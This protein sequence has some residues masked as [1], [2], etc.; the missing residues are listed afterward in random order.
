MT[1]LDLDAIQQREQAATPGPWRVVMD[2][3][4]RPTTVWRECTSPDHPLDEDPGRDYVHDDCRDGEIHA[5][6]FFREADAEFI[7]HA[8]EDVPA[9]RREVERLRSDLTAMTRATVA[10]TVDLGAS[11][12]ERA[13]TRP[14]LVTA[15]ALLAAG[16]Y[17][18]APVELCRAFE[19]AVTAYEETQ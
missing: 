5:E 12:D 3:T 19:D 14:V 10:L 17:G 8:R 6:P 18:Y 9:L 4:E 15:R 7:A 11:V 13:R 16:G 2:D 1:D